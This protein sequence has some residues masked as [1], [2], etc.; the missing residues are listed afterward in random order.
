MLDE[1]LRDLLIQSGIA[2]ACTTAGALLLGWFVAGRA[3]RPVRRITETARVSSETNRS[4][5]MG[6]GLEGPQDE[7]QELADTLDGLLEAL[8]RALAS[9]RGF[10]VIVSHELRTPLAILRAEA[11]ARLACAEL[12]GDERLFNRRVLDAT[13]QGERTVAGLR[14]LARSESGLLARKAVDLAELASD[15]I[16]KMAATAGGV[17]FRLG[18]EEVVVRG[19]RFL[20]E[21]CVV[22]LVDNA[23]RYNVSVGWARV[24]VGIDRGAARLR[25]G[26]PGV[27]LTVE[28]AEA[29]LRLFTR[30]ERPEGS[31]CRSIRLGPVHLRAESWQSAGRSRWWSRG[32]P[33][34]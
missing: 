4:H 8:E 13:A 29:I 23:I 31:V 15:V 21:R 10:A 19:D 3:L 34:N 26:N 1:A 5:R 33:W 16:G 22:N 9:Q 28:E 18:L 25:V 6:M 2:L 14:A 32:V 24:A 7:L 17:E 12:G 20:P 11:D 27:Q 30:R